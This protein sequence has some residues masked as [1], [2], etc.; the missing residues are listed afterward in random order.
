M[1]DPKDFI[2]KETDTIKEEKI[3]V[4]GNF[5]CQECMISVYLASLDEDEMVLKY[6]C[7]DG[8]QNEATL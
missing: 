3:S 8:H 2:G 5:I 7:S 1:I 4:S 6:T